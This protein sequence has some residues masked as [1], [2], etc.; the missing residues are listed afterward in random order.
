[1]QEILRCS[2]PEFLARLSHELRTPLNVIL[3]WIQMVKSADAGNETVRRALR[4]I[5][6]SAH[7]Q[8][9]LIDDLVNVAEIGAGRLRLHARTLRLVPAITATVDALQPV[10]EAKGVHLEIELDAKTGAIRGDMEKIRHIVWNVLS[11]AVKSTQRG[12]TVRVTLHREGSS[13]AFAVS[14]AG[15]AYPAQF[16]PHALESIHRRDA[17]PREA[18][19]AL[20]VG[21]AVARYLA[22]MHGGSMEIDGSGGVYQGARFIVRFP[23]MSGEAPA[24]DDSRG[25]ASRRQTLAGLRILAVDDDRN[26]LE[27]LQEAFARAGADVEAAASACDALERLPRYRPH[28]LVSDIGMP[29]EDGCT[30]LRKIRALSPEE[31]GATPAV[32]LTGYARESDVAA[33]RRAGYQAVALKPVDLEELMLTIVEAAAR[34]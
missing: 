24:R 2:N 21:L 12:G 32:A 6:H 1:M 29:D 26:T 8:A 34:R 18:H 19:G 14:Y 5:E 23:L 28:V 7:T 31:G 10:I 17:A 4:Q 15:L 33:A 30:L 25:A 20:D 22:E 11:K 9:R 3:G 16:L 27:L 13:A